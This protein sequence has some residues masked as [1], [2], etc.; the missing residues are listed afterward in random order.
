[1]NSRSDWYASI[2]TQSASASGLAAHDE[3]GSPVGL[4]VESSTPSELEEEEEDEDED[5][6]RV[7]DELV[8]GV[9]VLDSWPGAAPSSPHASR[10]TTSTPMVR[11]ARMPR[12]HHDRR[13]RVRAPYSAPPGT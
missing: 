2:S 10:R 9:P 5:G 12:S 3:G 11:E 13:R 8:S 6:G 1:M 7:L 4:S